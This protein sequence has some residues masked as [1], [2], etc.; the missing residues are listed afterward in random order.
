MSKHQLIQF[1]IKPKT[2]KNLKK[3]AKIFTV[4]GIFLALAACKKGENGPAGQQGEQGVPGSA[5]VNVFEKD[6]SNAQWTTFGNINSGYLQ[7]EISAPKV[8]TAE[9]VNN[10]TNLVY[11]V[12][13]DFSSG[14]A[15]LP[16]YTERNIRVTATLSAGRLIL[17]RDQDGKPSTQSN[18]SKVRLISIKPSE[19]ANPLQYNPYPTTTIYTLN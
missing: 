8:L 17:K 11:V 7:L 14:W 3:L 12:S 10:W 15:L 4:L 2:M 9:V 16:Y 1:T 19:A 6:I 18:F 5:N 13:S